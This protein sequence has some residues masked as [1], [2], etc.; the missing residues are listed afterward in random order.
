MIGLGSKFLEQSKKGTFLYFENSHSNGD[1]CFQKNDKIP[2][3]GSKIFF[4]KIGLH[5]YQKIRNFVG[6]PKI[7][8]IFVKNAPKK[9]Y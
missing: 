3:I 7:I 5:G 6:I 9:S 2:L 4:L 1:F 8:S